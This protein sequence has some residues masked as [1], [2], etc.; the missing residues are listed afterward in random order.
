MGLAEIGTPDVVAAALQ[1]IRRLS[2]CHRKRAPLSL[3]RQDEGT[4]RSPTLV[5]NRCTARGGGGYSDFPGHTSGQRV[6]AGR[7]PPGSRGQGRR[8]GAPQIGEPSALRKRRLPAETRSPDRGV[9]PAP[10]GWCLFPPSRTVAAMTSQGRSDRCRH[11]RH[12]RACATLSRR[13]PSA[14]PN[15]T[16]TERKLCGR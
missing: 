15:G 6:G 14:G 5:G 11:R 7:L 2:R 16:P 10:F 13:G 3:I 9:F 8:V 1:G 4:I 12:R